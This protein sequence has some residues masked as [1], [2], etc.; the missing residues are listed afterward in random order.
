M[1]NNFKA[2]KYSKNF[3]HKKNPTP[4]FIQSIDMILISIS[5]LLANFS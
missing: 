5:K 1:Y 2:S 4:F 3:D